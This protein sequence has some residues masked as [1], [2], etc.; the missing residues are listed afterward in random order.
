MTATPAHRIC[1]FCEACCGLE[2]RL[3]DQGRVASVRGH[4]ADVFSAGFMCPKGVAI[5][6]LQDDPDR[7]RTPLIKR[8]GV[9]EPA[10]WDEA[11]DE[12]ERRLVPLREKHGPHAVAVTA[13]NPSS[14]KMG[15][16]LYYGRLFKAM[17][18]RN[19]YSA[20]TLDQMPKQLSSGLMFGH[21]LSIAIPDI[22]RTDWLLVLGANPVAS[23][24]SLWT[25]PDFRGK[26]RALKARGGRL[27]VVDPRRTETAELADRHLTIRPGGDVYLLLGMVAT[28]FDEHLV[29]LG[30]AGPHVTGVDEVRAAVAP[31]PAE[32]VATRCGIEAAEIR[33]LA[34]E[35][36]AAPHGIV[37]GRM[38]TCAQ[39]FG[40]LCSW[41]IDVLNTLTGNLDQPGGVMFPR[42]PAFQANSEGKPGSG[43]GIVTGRHH[44]RVS[45]APEV[46]GELPMVCLAEE[47]ETPGDGQVRALITIASNPVLSA[48]NGPRLSRAMAGLEF[49]VSLDIYL[50]ETSR[51]AD[52]ILPGLA[53]LEEAH[54]DVAFHQLAYRNAARYSAPVLPAPAGHVPEWQIL[55]KL[56]AIAKGLGARADVVALDTELLRADLAKS[57]GDKADDVLAAVAPLVGPERQLE[58]ALRTGPYGDGFGAKPDGLTLAKLRAAPGGIDFGPLQPRLPG[59]LRTPSGKV[60]LAP[61]MLLADLPRAL[62]DLPQAAPEFVIVGR[63][64][65]RSNNSWMHNLPTLAKGPFRC[66]ALI[67]PS[68]AA[69]LGLVDGGRARIAR[70]GATS[71]DA[72]VAVSDEVM[73]GVISL[74]HGWGH[75]LPGVKLSVAAER[76][77]VNLNDVL[78]ETLR[79]P[80]SGNA[81]L[82]GVAVQVAAL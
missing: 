25:V 29:D 12:I 8:N 31:F 70:G 5:K 49:M 44:A 62:A 80:L 42:A 52:V 35:L 10:S 9:F 13:G 76:P 82:G 65:V 39:P 50:N 43:R 27:V 16:M 53:P 32:A 4:E 81:V 20:S 11:F 30:A 15:L 24:G 28:L 75:G 46:F 73:P 77:G 64:Q 69:R 63:R 19:A 68:D 51:H 36:A 47:I 14:H 37:Y 23:N 78:D 60:E 26:A 17:G 34:R 40:T 79:D 7:L 3:D 59:L 74:P 38:G 66:T 22:E 61:A 18:T 67:H 2:V 41:L 6:D 54:Y 45:G 57:M 1:P 72:E 55:L 56:I 33:R 58:L 71:I 21:W 48:P